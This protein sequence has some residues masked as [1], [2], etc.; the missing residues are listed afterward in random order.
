MAET[1]SDI[2]VEERISGW[3]ELIRSEDYW[4]IWLG[5]FLLVVAMIL[6]IPNPPKDMVAKFDTSNTTMQQESERA[7]FRTIAYLKAQD[8]K[9]KLKAN[10]VMPIK[11]LFGFTNKPGKWTTNPISSFYM[12]EEDAAAIRDANKPKYDKAKLATAAAL[13]AATAAEAAAAAGQFGDDTLNTTA[14][15]AIA[16]WRAAKKAESKAKKKASTKAKNLIPT[17]IVL[18]IAFGIFF[19]IG[20]PFMGLSAKKFLIAF[21]AVFLIAVLAYIL[22]GQAQMKALGI[23][24]VLFALVIGLVIANTVG[25]PAWTKYCLN[26]VS[27][28]T[29]DSA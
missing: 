1:D 20:V 26:K 8:A 16:S 21:P 5:A 18:M 27:S 2:V 3:S 10:G 17:M 4:S 14:K 6:V 22:A 23:S 24:Y 13:A 29:N 25:T 9:G 19:S 28:T 12:S 11:W 15:E 7:P